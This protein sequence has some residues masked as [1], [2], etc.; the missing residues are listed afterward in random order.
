[1]RALEPIASGT[2]VNPQDGFTLTWEAFGDEGPVVLLLPT[3]M[4]VHSRQWKFQI[5]FLAR[6][7]R[8]ITFDPRGNG[9]SER[10]RDP[11][12]HGLD[13]FAGDAIAVLDACGHAG[14]TVVGNSVGGAVALDVAAEHP[15]RVDALV[16]LGPSLRGLGALATREVS[17]FEATLDSPVGWELFNRGVWLRD[18]PAFARFF[19]DQCLSEPHST[20]AWDDCVGWALATDGPTLAASADA[21]V[22]DWTASATEVLDR[23]SRLR[24][25]TLLIHGDGDRISWVGVSRQAAEV[26]PDVRYVEI[27]GGGHLP[28]V[29]DPIFV[30]LAIDRFLDEVHP[31]PAARRTWS[32]GAGRR[33][34]VLYISSPIGLGHARRDIAIA[35]ELAELCPDVEIDWLAQ[36]PVTAVLE[37]EGHRVHPASRWL[38]SESQSFTERSCEHNLHAFQ[39]LRE[40]D[41]IFVANFHTFQT[42]VDDGRYDLVVADE[43]WDIDHFWFENPELKRAPLAWM[44]DFVGYLPMSSGG[45]REAFVAADYNAEMIEH[46]ARYPAMRDRAIFVGDPDDIVPLSFGPD[47]PEIRS[48]TQANFAFAGYISGFDPAQLG[49]REQLRDELGFGPDETVCVVAVGGSGV[50]TSLLQRAVDSFHFV[51]RSVPSLRMVVVCGPRISPDIFGSRDG[52]DVIGFVPRLYRHFAAC[53]I[54]FVQ[55]GLTTTMELVASRR[56]FLYCPLEDHFE[57]QIHVRHRLDRYRAGRCISPRVTPEEIAEA[58]VDVLSRPVDYAP[59]A[60]DGAYRAASSIAELLN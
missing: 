8:V 19:L 15:D 35:G 50:G 53:D 7:H 36:H 59:V 39:A 25:P 42:V 3:W 5:P 48:W 28:H 47:L 46:V 38:A 2:A 54:A 10:T 58:L 21:R 18:Y 43:A 12:H 9:A 52:L 49:E 40:M 55:G 56:P 26:I 11:K 4:I 44:T 22:T 60:V 45:E 24:C 17:D 1:M 20:K 30:N 33:R 57:Q 41:E 51:R 16:L 29:R 31:R 23:C 32:R 27:E 13:R 34:K 6:R 37:G 14:A